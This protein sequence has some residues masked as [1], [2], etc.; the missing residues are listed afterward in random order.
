MEKVKFTD[1]STALKTAVVFSY[2]LGITYTLAFMVGFIAA[3][4]EV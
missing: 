2:I 3:M 4:L 1:L